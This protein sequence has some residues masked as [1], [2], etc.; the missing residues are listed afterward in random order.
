MKLTKQ[1]L[2]LIVRKI[3]NES[4]DGLYPTVRDQVMGQYKSDARTKGAYGNKNI[5]SA[6]A[7]LGVSFT[8]AGVAIDVKDFSV[9]YDEVDNWG[10]LF[11]GIG[12]IP[13]AGDI[14]KNAYKLKKVESAAKKV[15]KLSTSQAAEIKK[16]QAE[17]GGKID[18]EDLDRVTNIVKSTG[19]VARPLIDISQ[20]G[21]KIFR[22]EKRHLELIHASHMPDLQVKPLEGRV[23]RQ[24]KKGSL[25]S[26][27]YT[28]PSHQKSLS[29]KKETIDRAKKYVDEMTRKN[30]EI[31]RAYVYKLSIDPKANFVEETNPYFMGITRISPEK[32]KEYYD[33]GID[34]II[35]KSASLE[36]VIILNKDVIT[37]K[38]MTESLL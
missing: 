1:Q 15:G 12:F 17:G 22:P 5:S 23:T 13:I 38:S 14:A 34:V 6:L 16:L 10:M 27:F 4:H 2:S 29:T 36:E 35:T 19:T 18:A 8:P 26:G 32:A 9:A 21:F 25:K 31:D 7:E 20:F 37:S 11:A 30:P 3:L 28:Y 24:S 33:A